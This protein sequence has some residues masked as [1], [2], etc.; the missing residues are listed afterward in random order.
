MNDYPINSFLYWNIKEKEKNDWPLYYFF[1]D[2]D[3]SSPHNKGANLDGITGNID[4]L[5]DGQQRLTSL[6]I[7]LN[8]HYPDGTAHTS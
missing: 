3:D 5:L 2:F 6:A 8:R 4:L 7:G 1:Y